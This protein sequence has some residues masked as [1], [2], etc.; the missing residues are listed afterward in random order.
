MLC[1]Y[2]HVQRT[3]KAAARYPFNLLSARHFVSDPT[4]LWLVKFVAQR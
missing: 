4:V 1:N 3:P 2:K